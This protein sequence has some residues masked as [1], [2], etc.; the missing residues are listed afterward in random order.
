MSVT[1]F[2]DFGNGAQAALGKEPAVQNQASFSIFKIYFGFDPTADFMCWAVVIRRR[3]KSSRCSRTIGKADPRFVTTC[4]P[5]SARGRALRG[6]CIVFYLSG[7]FGFVR[8]S[9]SVF[10]SACGRVSS[11]RVSIVRE[12]SKIVFPRLRACAGCARSSHHRTVTVQVGGCSVLLRLW[13]LVGGCL[14]MHVWTRV[15]L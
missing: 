7:G 4:Q 8:A 1:W 9:V 14:C 10:V 5:A 6:C 11:T 13:L 2:L 15:C 3:G 12:V